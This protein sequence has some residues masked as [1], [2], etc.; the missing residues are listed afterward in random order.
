VDAA[1]W[2]VDFVR[3]HQRLP[4]GL[5][6]HLDREG[7][8]VFTVEMLSRTFPSLRAFDQVSQTPILLFFEPPSLDDRIVNQFALHS[9]MSSPREGHADLMTRHPDLF[10]RVILPGPLKREVR[11]KLDQG[12]INERVLFP[13]LDGL[14]QWLTRYYTPE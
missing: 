12:N 4:E 7:S 14:A 3:T 13:G 8:E 11:D 5:R 6:E 1:I 9:V 10:K 2:C